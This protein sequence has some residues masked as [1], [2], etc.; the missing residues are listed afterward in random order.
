M[1]SIPDPNFDS[2]YANLD[3]L[4]AGKYKTRV[5]RENRNR[6]YRKGAETQDDLRK[7]INKSYR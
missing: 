7:P 3:E 1:A 6:D 4:N 2:Y 5:N